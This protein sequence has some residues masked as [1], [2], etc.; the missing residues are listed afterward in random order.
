MYY[1]GHARNEEKALSSGGFV[2]ALVGRRLDVATSCI[3]EA[4]IYS[5]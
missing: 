1:H 3:H 2:E 4:Y 5:V